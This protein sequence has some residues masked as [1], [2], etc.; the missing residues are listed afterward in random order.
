M[1]TDDD[2]LMLSGLQ[3]MLFCPRQCGLIH[4]AQQW[5]ENRF[6]AEGQVLHE[7]ADKP[8]LAKAGNVK[9]EYAVPIRSLSLGLTGRADIVEFHLIDSRWQPYPVEYKRGRP[10]HQQWD[11]VQLCAQAICLEEMMNTEIPEGAL[12]YGQTRHRKIIALSRELRQL[13]QKTADDF[14]HMVDSGKIPVM[15]YDKKRCDNCSL[16]DIC[17]PKTAVKTASK[18]IMEALKCED[19]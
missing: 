10:K 19:F 12:F 11:E 7:R 13:T 8:G 5:E 1:Y 17:L 9:T 18:Y 3:H 14:H 2:L 6:T 15:E 4:I 16:M